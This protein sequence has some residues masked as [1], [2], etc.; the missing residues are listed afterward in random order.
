MDDKRH[1]GNSQNSESEHVANLT[2]KYRNLLYEAMLV[3]KYV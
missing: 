2:E 3:S 1:S